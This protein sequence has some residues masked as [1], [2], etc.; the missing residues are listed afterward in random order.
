MTISVVYGLWYDYEKLWETLMGIYVLLK[1]RPMKSNGVFTLP[2]N[3]F[4]LFSH[5]IKH[6]RFSSSSQYGQMQLCNMVTS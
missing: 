4:I 5:K 2:N 3:I 1:Y 6:G